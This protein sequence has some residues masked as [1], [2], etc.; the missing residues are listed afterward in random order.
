MFTVISNINHCL[1]SALIGL[2]G[3][4]VSDFVTLRHWKVT[5]EGEVIV[6]AGVAV[7]HGDMP[8]ALLH[9]R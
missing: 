7:S 1:Q 4:C 8:P 3:C 9:V 5:E 6:S 2:A